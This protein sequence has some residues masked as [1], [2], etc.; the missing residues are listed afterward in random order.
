MGR[1]NRDTLIAKLRRV[2]ALHAGATTDGEREAASRA[3]A[4]LVDRL[5]GDV[6]SGRLAP[7]PTIDPLAP[8][9]GASLDTGLRMP[10]HKTIIK[11][12][13]AWQQGEMTDVQLERW[14]RRYVDRMLLPDLPPDHID[15]IRVEM[16]LQ[17][18]SLT[19]QPLLTDD[20]PAMVA[21][22]STKKRQVEEGWRAWFTY[23][24]SID[25]H[26][27]RKAYVPPSKRKKSRRKHAR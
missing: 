1:D 21:F 11:K 15:S 24:E 14:A 22:L 4:R 6:P 27:R 10:M 5:G 26:A 3:R 8:P 23:I 9:P 18:S 13:T 12:V 16:V 19:R 7:P 2:E 17:L 25:W 20:V